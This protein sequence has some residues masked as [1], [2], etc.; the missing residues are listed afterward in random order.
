MTQFQQFF[1][2]WVICSLIGLAIG[3]WIARRDI[4]T[5]CRK[6]GGFYVGN[7]TVTVEKI[8]GPDCYTSGGQIPM[9]RPASPP[10]VQ[11]T[12]ESSGE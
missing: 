2:D 8:T 4:L 11:T 5:Q 6:L 9:H 3:M 1:F 12:S 7:T 10:P